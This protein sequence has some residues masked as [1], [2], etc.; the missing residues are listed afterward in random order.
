M[1]SL[2]SVNLTPGSKFGPDQAFAVFEIRQARIIPV[3]V[4]TGIKSIDCM[5]VHMP[6]SIDIQHITKSDYMLKDT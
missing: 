3:L 5:L 2:E 1:P 4:R 6:G